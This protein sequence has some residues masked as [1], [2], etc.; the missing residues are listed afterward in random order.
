[1]S[2][3][4]PD[5]HRGRTPVFATEGGAIH[6]C[7]G[8]GALHV[9]IGTC[10]LVLPTEALEPLERALVALGA[11]EPESWLGGRG[12]L[13]IGETGTSLA[14]TPAECSDAVRLIA[15]ASLLLSLEHI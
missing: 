9:R 12:Q 5:G 3:D 14:L 11:D 7:S 1:M 8:C 13:H 10:I 15:G 2:R 4:C 6:R